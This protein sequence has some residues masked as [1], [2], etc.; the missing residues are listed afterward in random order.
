MICQ[1]L[2]LRSH[3]VCFAHLV[4]DAANHGEILMLVLTLLT[5]LFHLL[6]GL[7]HHLRRQRRFGGH[8]RVVRAETEATIRRIA[9]PAWVKQEV[10]RLKAL[11]PHGSCRKIGDCFNRRFER[12]RGMTV[13]KT[14]VSETIRRHRYEIDLLRREIKR[15]PPRLIP[16]NYIWAM[17]LTG[18]VDAQGKLRMLLGM[19]DHGS[20]AALCLQA[21]PNKS[22]WTLLGHLFLAIGKYGKPRFVRTD[23]EA[24]FTSRLFRSTLFALGIRHQT[25]DLHCP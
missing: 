11:M 7:A 18:K 4:V 13:G 10:L 12:A 23:N 8:R 21:L 9:K 3:P 1:Q 6:I 19:L 17:D 16:K 14:Y 25:T 5:V 15:R 24:V 20:R 22:S 2:K